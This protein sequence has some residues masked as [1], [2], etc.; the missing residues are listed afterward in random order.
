MHSN[1]CI[2]QAFTALTLNISHKM[3]YSG[4]SNNTILVEFF[5]IIIYKTHH[6]W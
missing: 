6:N 1:I 4:L 2:N 3:C 5:T